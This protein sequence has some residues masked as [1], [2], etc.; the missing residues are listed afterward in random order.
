MA[1]YTYAVASIRAMEPSLFSAATLEQLMACKTQAQCLQ[2]LAEKGWGSPDIPQ[3][4]DAILTCEREKTWK[5]IEDLQV[6]LSIFDVLSYQKQF[7]NLKA[8]IKEVCTESGIHGIFYE[9]CPLSGEAIMELLK[10]KSYEDLPASMRDAAKEAHETLL[11]TGDGQLCDVIVDRAALEA[12]LSAGQSSDEPIIRDYAESTVAVADIKIAAR[13]A[14]TG[15]SREFMLRALAPCE[16]LDCTQLSQ[17]AA[18]GSPALFAYLEGLGYGEA[19]EALRQSPS[20]F[21]R[22]C[23]DRIIETIQPQLFEAFSVG[24]L[25]AYVL[26]RENEINTVRIILSGKQN[27]LPEASIRERIRKMYV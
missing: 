1:N 18:S 5:T 20:A 7:H 4:V 8:A 14:A 10:S 2:F 24:P 15:K 13:S 21:E 27:D 3:T 22:W 25:V 16:S 23:D 19:V 9:D 26:A 11:Q 17:A 6:D 12:I